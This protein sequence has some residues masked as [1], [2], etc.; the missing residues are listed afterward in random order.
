[1]EIDGSGRLGPVRTALKLELAGVSHG[2]AP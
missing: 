2:Y 1:M